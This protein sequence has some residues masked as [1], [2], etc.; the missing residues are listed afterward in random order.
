MATE[1]RKDTIEVGAMVVWTSQAN[2][3]ALEKRGRVVDVVP[4]GARP[5]G[6]RE[7]GLPRDHESYLVR[8]TTVNARGRRRAGAYWP[9]VSA[10]RLL[11]DGLKPGDIR[12]FVKS[13]NLVRLVEP[14][15]DGHPDMWTVERVDTGKQMTVASH[16][17]EPVSPTQD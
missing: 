4:A 14:I 1:T 2:G 12:M 16:A 3:R 10:L 11:D 6:I 15:T 13:G 5:D 9:R 8:A 17:L 7:P